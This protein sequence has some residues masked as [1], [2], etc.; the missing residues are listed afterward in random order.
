MYIAFCKRNVNQS[1]DLLSNLGI[2]KRIWFGWGFLVFD[3]GCQ[4]DCH[5]M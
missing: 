4:S 1:S 2:G 5:Q 3:I